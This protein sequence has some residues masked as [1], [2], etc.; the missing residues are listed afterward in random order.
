MALLCLVAMLLLAF[1]FG[2]ERLGIA[3]APTP[4]SR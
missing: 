4:S 2:A 1:A 3:L